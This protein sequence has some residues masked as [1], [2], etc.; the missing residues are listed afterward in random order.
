[1]P[2][3]RGKSN[4]AVSKNISK[5]RHE[6]YEQQQAVAIAMNVAGRKRQ[7]PKSTRQRRAGK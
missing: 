4:K 3:S 2:L 6:G 1:M 5:L 7:Q